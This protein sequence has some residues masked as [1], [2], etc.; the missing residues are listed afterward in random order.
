[1]TTRCRNLARVSMI[2]ALVAMPLTLGACGQTGKIRLNP[3]PKVASLSKSRSEA[4]N[5]WHYMSNT[6]FRAMREDT[7]RFLLID[8]PSRLV[9]TTT[10]Y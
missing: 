6:N 8:R 3:A 10:P 2:A 1:M 5:N 7:A 9:Y 4:N